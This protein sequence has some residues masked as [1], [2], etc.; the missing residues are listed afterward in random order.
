MA[1]DRSSS[2]SAL[3]NAGAAVAE[4]SPVADTKGSINLRIEA[5]TRQLI[6]DAASILGKERGDKLVA[7]LVDIERLEDVL[8][9]RPLLQSAG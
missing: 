4:R 6:D 9:L 2:T 8:A 1:K 5:N 3:G 7:A